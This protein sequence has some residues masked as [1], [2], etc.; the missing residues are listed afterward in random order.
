MTRSLRTRALLASVS[1]LLVLGACGGSD[2]D[3]SSAKE[4]TSAATPSV[5]PAT[6]DE[7]EAD[8]FSFTA[9]EG[10]VDVT[11][12]IPGYTPAAAYSAPNATDGFSANVNVLQEPNAAGVSMDEVV[13]QGTQQLEAA[14]FTEVE[15]EDTIE[16]D[17]AETAVLTAQGAQNGVQYRTR[18]YFALADDAAWV[19]TFSFPANSDEADRTKLAESVMTTWSW[20]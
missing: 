20:A 18:Q 6:G 19:I 17:G 14:G 7:V 8:G 11:D 16:V 12:K 4:T 3:T 13:E 10:W 2:D 9:P 1:T 15:A 5:E